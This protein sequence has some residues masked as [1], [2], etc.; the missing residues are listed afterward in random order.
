MITFP[1]CK[2]SLA[3][4]KSQKEV[5]ELVLN[6]KKDENKFYIVSPPGSGKTITGLMIAAELRIPA[7]VLV[8]N[9]AIQSQWLEKSK[10]FL[11]EAENILLAS[12]NPG[13]A[14]PL[15]VMTYQMLAQSRDISDDEKNNILDEWRKELVEEG[16]EEAD[17]AEWLAD[18]ERNNPDRFFLSLMRRFKNAR[19]AENTEPAGGI[20]DARA[21]G[22]MDTLRENGVGLV[23]FDECHHLVGYWAQV[24]LFLV[25]HLGSP[26]VVGFT[27]TPPL[28]DDLDDREVELHKE[29]LGDID[30][31]VIAPAVI[32]DGFLAPYQ[33]LVYFTRP[34]QA[35]LEFIRNCSGTLGNIFR[36][37]ETK[38][39]VKMSGW[40]LGELKEISEKSSPFILRKRAEFIDGA[41]KYLR[42]NGNE[43]PSGF[44]CSDENPLSLEQKADLLGRY[45][46]KCLLSSSEN[47]VFRE[48]GAALRPLGYMLTEK[49]MRSCQSTVNRVLGLSKSKMEGM[50]NVLSRELS[51]NGAMV[52][53]I[54]ISDFERSSAISATSASSLLNAES[55]GA[56]AAMRALASNET[57][58]TLDPIMLTG[59]SVFVDDDLLPKFLAAAETWI[60]GR[61]LDARIE[62]V[63]EDGFFVLN[64]SGRDWNTRTYITMISEFFEK[65]ITRCLVGTR[66]LLGEGWDSLVANTLIDLTCA[67]TAMTVNQLRGRTIRL[68]P[69]NPAKVSNIWD[70]VCLAPEY[71]QGLTD[72]ARFAKKHSNYY[73]I[74]DDGAIEFGLGH[75]HPA[76]TEAGPEDVALNSHIFNEEML[77]RC[78]LRKKIYDLWEIGK[79][80]QDRATS[81]L[82]LKLDDS[83]STRA[84]TMAGSKMR[85]YDIS[86]D[87]KM[88]N[89]C[90]AVFDALRICNA[91]KDRK[92]QIKVTARADRYFRVFLDSSTPEDMKIFTATIEELFQPIDNQKYIIPRYEQILRDR[93]FSKMLPQIVRKYFA[94]KI[95]R[96]A[97]YHPVPQFFAES[98]EKADL[99]SDR[100]NIYVS[101]GRAIF[102]KRGEGEKLAQDA[103]FAN[104]SLKDAKAKIKSVWK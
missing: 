103:K 7:L 94:E 85:G 20:V 99:F 40:L 19:F 9:T 47:E 70:I 98:R 62:S 102:T 52:R 38:P 14:A 16:E 72:Y 50:I 78:A 6:K 79:P 46:A 61:K 23:I 30:Y 74:C 81:A 37:V 58:D 76:L 39:S 60:A 22:I 100:W 1:K 54:V 18:Y 3:P 63:R 82:E 2:I 64:G 80:Y 66:G 97:V 24:A 13:D 69:A 49:G 48:L 51:I 41:V 27:A 12:I 90:L 21:A 26:K 11:P 5:L 93:W 17:A 88:R 15:T 42:E 33:D 91:L 104:Q 67:A 10:S 89:I 32:K 73:G 35:E 95:N 56:V 57:T 87:G 55:G 4:R 84:V 71:E 45:A 77:E 68:D 29:L 31:Q 25:K 75:I 101:P 83:F 36:S 65:G 96:V 86:P 53:A 59:K 28:F 34:E 43:V 44:K 92:A 8:P